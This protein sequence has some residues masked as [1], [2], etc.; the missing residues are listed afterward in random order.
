MAGPAVSIM[1]DGDRD[2]DGCA[3]PASPSAGLPHWEGNGDKASGTVLARGPTSKP[4]GQLASQ[5]GHWSVGQAINQP[6]GN[7]PTGNWPTSQ[8]ANQ[9]AGQAAR[10]C[11]LAS[12]LP[13]TRPANQPMF[14]VAS[15]P[16][17]QPGTDQ[18]S[19]ATSHRAPQPSVTMHPASQPLA[20]SCPPKEPA[21]QPGDHLPSI[22][23]PHPHVSL[24]TW[25]G[26]KRG[27]LC[28][29]A[30]APGSPPC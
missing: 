29:S 24:T 5:S 14:S 17:S 12:Q 19:P 16:I 28:P 6:T 4:L 15:K 2:R 23:Q 25:A 9:L 22:Q 1:R 11:Q 27:H 8:P 20:A 3:T 30:L 18:S 13:I 7:W 10:L 21:S 26:V